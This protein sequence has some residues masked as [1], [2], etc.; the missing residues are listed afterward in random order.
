MSTVLRVDPC[1]FHFYSADGVEAP[2]IHVRA[3][4]ARA[5]FWLSPV[6]FATSVGFKPHELRKI[7]RLVIKRQQLFL[8]VWYDYFT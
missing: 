6:R 1:R 7:E 3:G 4:K 2:H 8:E 5:K